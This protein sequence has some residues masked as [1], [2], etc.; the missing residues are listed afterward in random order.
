VGA[1]DGYAYAFAAD[2]RLVFKAWLGGAVIASPGVA[3]G[4]DS[5]WATER[6]RVVALSPEGAQ[7][8]SHQLDG[9]VAAGLA[10]DAHRRVL[11]ATLGPRVWLYAFDPGDG[12]ELS[13]VALARTDGPTQGARHLSSAAAAGQVSVSLPGGDLWVFSGLG[14]PSFRVRTAGDVTSVLPL[15]DRPWLVVGDRGGRVRG[16]DLTRAHCLPT[17]DES[18]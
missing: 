2:G 8:W 10:L 5:F 16:L 7:R 17:G 14:E 4:G 9:D 6:G 15:T 12:R 11:V 13:R 1:H 3:E 18:L